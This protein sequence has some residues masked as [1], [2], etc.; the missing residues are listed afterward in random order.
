MGRAIPDDHLAYPVHVALSR[1]G[2]GS[3]FFL[4]APGRT[5]LVTAKHV[6]Y[7]DAGRL[8]SDKAVCT[9]PA[10]D[11]L[12]AA[13]NRLT[14]DL[15]ALDASGCVKQHP[16][17]DVAALHVG[18]TVPE[19]DGKS[20]SFALKECVVLSEGS[21]SGVVGVPPEG[22][23]VLGD[24]LVG[25]PV[26]LFGYPASLGLR[27][28]PQFDYSQ[29]LLRSGIVAGKY[30]E[31]GTLIF[32]CPVFPGNSGGPV[33]EVERSGLNSHY[34]VIGVASQFV[35]LVESTVS[36]LYG[37][38]NTNISNSGY[39]VAVAMDAVFEML[40]VSPSKSPSKPA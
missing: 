26:F 34:R 3:A 33:V 32:D 21:K 30:P 28:Q 20:F 9:C 39:S 31:Q 8:L 5:F 10:R 11:P 38:K 2:Q 4:N 13:R 24:V 23:K 14:L 17:R 15:A 1:G 37:Y 35:P 12:E 22:T 25:N 19:A 40:Q 7:S 36:T 29:P 27:E 18:D 16:T 6:L